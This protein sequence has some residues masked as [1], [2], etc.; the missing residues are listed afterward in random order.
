MKTYAGYV[1]CDHCAVYDSDPRWCALCGKAKET[2]HTEV[3]RDADRHKRRTSA[4][5]ANESGPSVDGR[6][7]VRRH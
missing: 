3:R 7:S 6:V 5:S 2:A 4:P 1:Q